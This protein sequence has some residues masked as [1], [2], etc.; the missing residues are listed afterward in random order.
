M[1]TNVHGVRVYSFPSNLHP[2]ER[3]Y[4]HLF[5]SYKNYPDYTTNELTTPK[6]GK[7]LATTS[8]IKI[9]S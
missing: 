6:S 9:I 4:N 5:N 3:I 8:Q 1:G 7:I 2:N